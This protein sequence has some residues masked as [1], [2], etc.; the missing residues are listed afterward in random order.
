MGCLPPGRSLQRLGPRAYLD[1]WNKV[2][3]PGPRQCAMPR[4]PRASLGAM[5]GKGKARGRQGDRRRA[6]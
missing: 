4:G 5:G 6:G 1:R 3:A 2:L